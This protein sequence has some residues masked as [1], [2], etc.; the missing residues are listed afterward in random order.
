[1]SISRGAKLDDRSG[2]SR[3]IE[4]TGD[5]VLPLTFS[6]RRPSAL[7]PAESHGPP[8]P[9]WPCVVWCGSTQWPAP[10]LRFLHGP[11]TAHPPLPP[12]A[13]AVHSNTDSEE[14]A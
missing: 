6:R 10:T 5:L 2:P 1:M 7:A 9:E 14:H 13:A 4:L 11:E 12:T 3:S 8:V